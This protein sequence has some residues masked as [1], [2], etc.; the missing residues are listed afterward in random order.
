MALTF[1]QLLAGAGRVGQGMREEQEAQRVAQLNEMRLR[2]A[3]RLEAERRAQQQA[4]LSY[5]M[6]QQAP[7]SDF[8][9]GLSLAQMQQQQAPA[10]QM[11]SRTDAAEMVRMQAA[12]QQAQ[13]QPA[14]APAPAPRQTPP[15]TLGAALT[16]SPLLGGG[17]RATPLG[18]EGTVVGGIQEAGT[19][20]EQMREALARIRQAQ[21]DLSTEEVFA[22]YRRQQAAMA[23]EAPV[24]VPAAPEEMP[25]VRD[26]E[27]QTPE[28][29]EELD[30]PA[31]GRVTQA[32]VSQE[33]Q[34][35]LDSGDFYLANPQSISR[36][37]QTVMNQRQNLARMAEMYR[38]AGL[39]DQ[40]LQ[41]ALKVEEMDN[42]L[43]YLQGIEGIE[44]LRTYNDPRRVSAVLRQVTGRNID[45]QPRPDGR[46]NEVTFD[47]QGQMQVLREGLTADAIASEAR[48]R[49]DPAARQNLAEISAERQRRALDLEF[50]QREE[51]VKTL[52]DMAKALQQGQIDRANTLAGRVSG[53]LTETTR[54]IFL[55]AVT[56]SGNIAVYRYNLATEGK[57]NWIKADIPAADEAFTSI[58]GIGSAGLIT[59]PDIRVAEQ[60][61]TWNE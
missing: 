6:P 20:R 43:L 29:T 9:P 2:E 59:R 3:Q 50:F 12:Q 38:R 60:L 57:S 41:T 8:R 44:E 53:A 19:R 48:L 49:I 17:G 34:Q 30:A 42:N 35:I 25:E 37:M 4:Q 5:Q 36:D 24:E 55:R 33:T 28:F 11:P 51:N 23:P 10:Q 47:A 18:G 15:A 26:G 1:G 58:P 22:E 21:P 27:V 40:Y 45:Y 52:N 46:Y 54:G 16:T 31:T 13:A 56:P 14:P 32:G 39:G 61:Q 7:V